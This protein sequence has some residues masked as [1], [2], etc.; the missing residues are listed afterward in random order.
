MS[1]KPVSRLTVIRIL[2]ERT[3][4]GEKIVLCRCECGKEVKVQAN[5]LT[6]GN[7]R[8]CGCLRRERQSEANRTHGKYGTPEHASWRDMLARCYNPNV[9]GYPYYG[10]IGVVVADR[11]RGENGFSNFLADMGLKPSPKHTIDRHPNQAGNYEPGNC[12]WATRKEQSRNRKS[13]VLLEFDGRKQMMCEWEEEN[14]LNSGMIHARLKLG[15][16]V[17][18]AITTP[19]RKLVRKAKP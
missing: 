6:S 1:E 4:G 2:E 16:S 7:T 9:K 5:N 17:E 10:A 13:N 3:D 11:W 19:A 8:S 15:W 18:R 14:G 12:R